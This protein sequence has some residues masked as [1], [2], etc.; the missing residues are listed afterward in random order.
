VEEQSNNDAGLA[1]TDSV[2]FQ[3]DGAGPAEATGKKSA[4]PGEVVA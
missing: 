1:D 2:G 4:Q 3:D